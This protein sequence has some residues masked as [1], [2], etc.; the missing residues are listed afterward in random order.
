MPQLVEN[1][2]SQSGEGVSLA[3]LTVWLIGDITNLIGAVW[4]GLV[5]TVVALAIY[6]C[7]ADVVLISQCLYYNVK[8]TRKDVRRNSLGSGDSEIDNPEQPLLR[9][10]ST[11]IGLP[12]SRRHSSASLK[13]QDSA[14]GSQL[15]SIP[16]DASNSRAWLKNS[17]CVILVC[18]AGSAGWAIAWKLGVWKSSLAEVDGETPDRVVGAEVLGYISATCY[19]G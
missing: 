11:N 14:P 4:A 18:L 3:F 2:Q 19:L 15:P 6:F 10:N 17:L 12:G 16:E 7:F 1:Y 8:N 9:S 5:P 13:R